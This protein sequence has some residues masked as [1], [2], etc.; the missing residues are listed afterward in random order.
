[1]RISTSKQHICVRVPLRECRSIWSGAS[2]L[3]YYCTPLVC[4]S[5]VIGLLA[6]WRHNKP[7]TKKKSHGSRKMQANPQILW[8][9]FAHWV[10]LVSVGNGPG[11]FFGSYVVSRVLTTKKDRKMDLNSLRGLAVWRLYKQGLCPFS[12]LVCD[13]LL[14]RLFHGSPKAHCQKSI[15][16]AVTIL[17]STAQRTLRLFGA[18]PTP[19]EGHHSLGGTFLGS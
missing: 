19:V 12:E 4:I 3:P 11:Q 14:R 10:G 2:G 16:L 17:S 13:L 8:I 18:F 5:A 9:V 15:S 1:M 7:K 6:V